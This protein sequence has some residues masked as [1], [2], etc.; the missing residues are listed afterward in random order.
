MRRGAC[1][2]LTLGEE[3]A[4][5]CRVCCSMARLR[6]AAVAGAALMTGA[7]VALAGVIGFVGLARSAA[8]LVRKGA[9]EDPAAV[10]A[11]SALAGAGLVVLAD[12]I[13]RL[14]PTEALL[15]LQAGGGDGPVRRALVHPDRL[16]RGAELARMRPGA[17]HP[18]RGGPRRRGRTV[19]QAAHLRVDSGE[20]VGRGDRA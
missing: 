19:L 14:I 10:L 9:K 11:P 5:G 18:G 15:E 12:L 17:G 13:G 6:A 7:A 3:T 16:A 1:A 4:H 2:S 8:L 20:I